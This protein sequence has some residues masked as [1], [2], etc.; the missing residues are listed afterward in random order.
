MIESNEQNEQQKPTRKTKKNNN[1]NGTSYANLHITLSHE[2]YFAT[3]VLL[4]FS[5]TMLIGTVDQIHTVNGSYLLYQ[6]TNKHGTNNIIK[7]QTS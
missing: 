4:R 3:N 6:L 7:L 5:T 1:D 2:R